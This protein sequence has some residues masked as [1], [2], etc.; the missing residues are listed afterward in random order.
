MFVHRFGFALCSLLAILLCA[1]TVS[2]EETRL[3]VPDGGY[4]TIQE[5]LNAATAGDIIEVRGGLYDAPLTIHE[6]VTLIGINRPVIDA[7]NS[8]SIVV[9]T[10]NN[11]H[12]EGF[13]LRNS[14][15]SVSREDTGIV[16]QAAGV[17]VIDNT[18]EDV[19]HGIYFADA[20]DGLARGNSIRC[21]DHELSRRGDGLRVWYSNDVHLDGNKIT[22]CRDTLIWHA[23]RI[24]I[25]NNRIQ[26]GMY[27]LH[28][29][30]SDDAII[31]NNQFSGNSVGTYLMYSRHL[32]LSD[33]QMLWN[34]GPSGYG[35]AL[36]DA[37]DVVVERNVVAGNRSALYLDNSPTL[38]DA[39]NR[40]I[41]NLFAY[42]DIGISALPSV[43]HNIFQRNAFLENTQQVSTLGRGNL[44]RNI[45]Q[46]DGFGNY[47]SDYIGYDGNRD[48]IG[49]MPY[50]AEK[51]FEGL[52]D[53]HAAL[54]LFTYS[55]A[56]QTL[57]FA[58]AAF[59]SLRPD[60]KVIDDAPLMS[61]TIPGHIAKQG[62]GVSPAFLA[63]ALLLLGAGTVVCLFALRSSRNEGPHPQRGLR[64][65]MTTKTG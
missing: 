9:I 56:S 18:L 15:D 43:A 12:F 17:K 52:A 24:L 61:Y 33:N 39:N 25:E 49:D 45:W 60:P 29:M 5:A 6:S 11:V 20:S 46:L 10:A 32:T 48:G 42:N 63:A 3:I 2:G 41:D 8:G 35:I 31:R 36:K 50:R 47:W 65:P 55:P 34:R 58:A 16:V 13:T 30:Y 4:T 14:G 28:F 23:Q 7:E 40:L 21:R 53:E 38:S 62:Q 26:D 44:L 37:D 59:P 27:G 19:L 51:L 22:Q 64:Q 54:R 1:I 57:N